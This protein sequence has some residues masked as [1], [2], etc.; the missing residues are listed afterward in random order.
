MS[1]PAVRLVP[2]HLHVGTANRL[3]ASKPVSL[4]RNKPVLQG[5]MGE[6]HVGRVNFIIDSTS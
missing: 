5:E 1:A 6:A 2:D 3:A 4:R